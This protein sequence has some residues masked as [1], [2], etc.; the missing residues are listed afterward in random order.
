MVFSE[1]KALRDFYIIQAHIYCTVGLRPVIKC[2]N[3]WATERRIFFGFLRFLVA[4]C[5]ESIRSIFLVTLL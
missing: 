3:F 5:S 2:D 4:V 1:E